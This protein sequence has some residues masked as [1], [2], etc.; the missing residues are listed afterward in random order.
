[1]NFAVENIALLKGNSVAG[2]DLTIAEDGTCEIS[3]VILKKKKSTIETVV[4]ISAI[5]AI[6][7]L[8]G[9]LKKSVPVILSI[10][11]KGII[12]KNVN[13]EA[14]DS[15]LYKVLPNAN[16]DLFYVQKF[17]A[18]DTG[19][20]VSVSRKELM[21][22]II[23]QFVA[24]GFIVLDTVMGPV[25]LDSAI[26]LFVSTGVIQTKNYR[27]TSENGHIN[28][29]ERQK[30]TG[31]DQILKLNNEEFSVDHVIPYANALSFFIQGNRN[32]E[33]IGNIPPSGRENF[34][35]KKALQASGWGILAAVF[36]ILFANYFFFEHFRTKNRAL[37]MELGFNSGLIEKMEKLQNELNLK[38]EM[39]EKSGLL[40]VS[41]LSFYADKIAMSVP[42]GIILS[43]MNINPV[44]EKIRP[45]E[46]IIF[47]NQRIEIEGTTKYSS[48]VNDW[49]K[50]LKKEDWIANV[51]SIEYNQESFSEPGEFKLAIEIKK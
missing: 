4:K 39:F 50:K 36:I 43:R 49:I 25:N 8:H 6:A 38:E 47:S 1:M 24:E 21:E 22:D 41:R 35:Y 27:I 12:H 18:A 11:G 45:G 10:N 44:A 17:I 9:R 7:D 32:I 23:S 48:L 5:A 46:Q 20:I 14:D 37:K 3:L 13:D 51:Q 30:N 2:I 42:H 15:I 19:K 40:N 28:G 31:Y 33:Y 34:I 26:Q 16:P 29:F